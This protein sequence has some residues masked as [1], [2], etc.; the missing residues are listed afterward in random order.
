[1]GRARGV[2]HTMA[3]ACNQDCHRQAGAQRAK[4][5]SMR[6]AGLVFCLLLA[7][8][9]TKKQPVAATPPPIRSQLPPSTAEL[10]EHCVVVNQEND[11][12][13][14]CRCVPIKTVIDSRTGHTTLVC[15]TVKEEQ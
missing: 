15:K 1:M 13:V 9:A 10:I 11:N 3:C 5:E 8:C 2:A 4:T 14:T 12:T 6:K 7:G